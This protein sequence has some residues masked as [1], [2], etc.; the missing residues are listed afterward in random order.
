MSK[1]NLAT[2]GAALTIPWVPLEF[3][4][5]DD[6][7]GLLV[8]Y[9]GSYPPHYHNKDEFFLVLS[10]AVD[11]EIEGEGTV[12]LQEKE[13]LVVRAG[14]HHRSIARTPSALVLLFEA[15][16]ITYNPVVMVSQVQE[17]D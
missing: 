9:Q 8:L 1:V 2:L 6:Y 15:K 7:H 11:V 16:D 14:L 17:Q 13:G 4:Q 12:T 5:V 3:A 10:G